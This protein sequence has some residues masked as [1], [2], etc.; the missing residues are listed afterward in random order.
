[1]ITQWAHPNALEEKKHLMMIPD[2][3]CQRSR[4]HDG[5]LPSYR[6]GTM[7]DSSCMVPLIVHFSCC[8]RITAK[9][10][11]LVISRRLCLAMPGPTLTRGVRRH[12]SLGREKKRSMCIPSTTAHGRHQYGY[13]RKTSLY[14][15]P[16]KMLIISD[17]IR[18]SAMH[19]TAQTPKPWNERKALIATAE[20]PK[21]AIQQ[22]L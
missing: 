5:R 13:R 14:T 6:Q 1:M 3:I 4:R 18:K 15:W 11:S 9:V 16:Q 12:R 2:R 17:K 21:Q 10:C 7:V 22:N 20:R 19:T 8:H